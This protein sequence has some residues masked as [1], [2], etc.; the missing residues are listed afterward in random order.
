T[1]IRS[2]SCGRP[3]L[4]ALGASRSLDTWG[5]D[6][7]AARSSSSWASARPKLRQGAAWLLKRARRR[8]RRRIRDERRNA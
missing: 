8:R 2:A 4:V 3:S 7:L 5:S 1:C 6:R